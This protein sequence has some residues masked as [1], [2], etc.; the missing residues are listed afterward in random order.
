MH[1]LDHLLATS[2][3]G[4]VGDVVRRCFGDRG[5]RGRDCSRG[6]VKGVPYIKARTETLDEK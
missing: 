1:A 4:V 3:A 2:S 5:V 6:G